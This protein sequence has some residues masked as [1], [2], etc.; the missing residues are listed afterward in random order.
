[1]KEEH[2]SMARLMLTHDE[3]VRLVPYRDSTGH[4]TIGVGRNLETRGITH[5][6]AS[7]MLDEDIERC[8]EAAERIFGPL[9]AEIH[10]VRQLG[11]LNMIF[12]LGEEGFKKWTPTIALMIANRW[13]EAAD[14]IAYHNPKYREQVGTRVDR[15]A[16]M[17]GEGE[18][19]Y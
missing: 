3:G 11:I 1:M 5:A 13:Q 18:F 16:T 9:W 14:R 8:E 17:I 4:L 6:T 10:P 7:Q 15:I 2:Q 12:N 19:P